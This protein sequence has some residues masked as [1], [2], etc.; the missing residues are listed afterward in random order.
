MYSS[1]SIIFRW[2]AGNNHFPLVRGGKGKART[3]YE[4]RHVP[5]PCRLQKY[6]FSMKYGT[7]FP[8]FNA[9]LW[10]LSKICPEKPSILRI[11]YLTLLQPKVPYPSLWRLGDLAKETVRKN[12]NYGRH[13][14]PIATPR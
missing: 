1:V 4:D 8:L 2:W 14:P 13:S 7:I 3:C 9:N 12:N 6:L 10:R 5:P 11:L